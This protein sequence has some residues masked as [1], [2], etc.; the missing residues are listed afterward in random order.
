[1]IPGGTAHPLLL[2]TTQAADLLG[3]S[4]ATLYRLLKSGAIDSVLIG[5][6]RRIPH[7]SLVAYVD[8]LRDGIVDQAA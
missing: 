1:M 3:V 4:R 2:T 5:R 8:G 7:A 6:L